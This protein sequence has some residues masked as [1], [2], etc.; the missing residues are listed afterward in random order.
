MMVESRHFLADADPAVARAQGPGRQSLGPRGDGR[1][2]ALGAARRRTAGRSTRLGSPRSRDGLFALADAH[3]VTLI[4]G[5]TTRGPRNL[6]VT[7]AGEVPI[8]QAV[9]RSGAT[10]GDDVWVSGTLGDAM[11]ALAAMQGRTALSA[12]E[13]ARCADAT[14]A[15][16][17]ARR[18]RT[19]AARRRERDARRLG[20]A[21]R[22]PRAHLLDAS[23][24]GRHR[25]RR[26]AF[27]A[28]RR[29]QAKLAGPERALALE[30]L[31]AGG[32]DYELCFTA[33]P[34]HASEV[35]ALA[36]ADCR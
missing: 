14:R 29:L 35:A 6:C 11:L 23:S 28:R 15:S 20:R 32:D 5:D 33:S 25:R 12:T 16:R 1:A 4:G 2:S 8:G 34:A 21:D 24:V 17:A 3:G 26:V 13:L 19:G 22:R 10:P 7:I 18:A 36:T 9:L 27:L 30:C 31:L